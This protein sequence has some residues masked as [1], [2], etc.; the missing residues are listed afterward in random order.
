MIDVMES[1]NPLFGR[2]VYGNEHGPP[3]EWRQQTADTK[4]AVNV[5][6]T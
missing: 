2:I 5:H 1:I 4:A 3:I 6:C